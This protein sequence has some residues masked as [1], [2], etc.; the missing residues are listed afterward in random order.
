M[1]YAQG[2]WVMVAG[3]CASRLDLGLEAE[4]LDLRFWFQDWDLGLQ[5]RVWT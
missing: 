4:I 5:A 3:I 2:N 1:T